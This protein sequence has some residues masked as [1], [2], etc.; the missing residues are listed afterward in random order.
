MPDSGPSAVRFPFD[1]CLVVGRESPRRSPLWIGVF[2][3][4]R[5]STGG[6]SGKVPTSSVVRRVAAILALAGAAIVVF[7]LLVGGGNPLHRHRQ[8]RERQPARQRQHGQRRRRRRRQGQGDQARR[9]RPGAGRAGGLRGVRPASRR[10]PTPPSAP[11]RSR[12]SPTA[13]STSPCRPPA[14][15]TRRSTDGGEIEQTDTTSEVDLDQLFNALDEDDRRQPE[16]GHQGLRPLLRRR[17]PP[18]QPGLLLPQPLPLDLAP[19][20]RRA[21]RRPDRPREPDRR[22]GLAHR[23]A[24]RAA[25]PTSSS[26]SGT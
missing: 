11:S 2:T 14:P 22:H 21:E 25:P 6:E 18:G 24:G 3:A 12:G 5:T 20:V 10:A 15:R 4:A 1:R 13:T 23:G 26:S 17:R 7:L 9:R 8:V 16:V 19:G